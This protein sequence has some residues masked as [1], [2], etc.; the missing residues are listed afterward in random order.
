MNYYGVKREIYKGNKSMPEETIIYPN[1][2]KTEEEGWKF[3]MR[4]ADFSV[5]HYHH[6]P[7]GRLGQN[8]Y[9]TTIQHLKCGRQR[10]T[11]RHEWSVIKFKME[12]GE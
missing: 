4:D 3:A 11:Y 5:L 10:A 9:T 1:I 8:G 7:V 2:Y 12:D 6:Q